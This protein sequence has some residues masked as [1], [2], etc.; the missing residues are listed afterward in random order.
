M[1]ICAGGGQ[2]FAGARYHFVNKK[3]VSIPE[4]TCAPAE[5]CVKQVKPNVA[6]L[7]DGQEYDITGIEEELLESLVEF[8]FNGSGVADVSEVYIRYEISG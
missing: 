1:C 6:T 2:R 5:P 3:A 4:D 8:V 7:A